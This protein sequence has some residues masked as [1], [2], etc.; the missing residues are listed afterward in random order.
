MTSDHAKVMGKQEVFLL[1]R[2]KNSAESDKSR[3]PADLQSLNFAEQFP[4]RL[5]KAPTPSFS[6][7]CRRVVAH[8]R[9]ISPAA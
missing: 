9:S 8:R 4:V 3:H 5:A 1:D 6:N 7:P 2:A